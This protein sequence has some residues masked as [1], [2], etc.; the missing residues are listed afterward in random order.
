M[1][2]DI[3]VPDHA[4]KLVLRGRP[5]QLYC[6]LGPLSRRDIDWEKVGDGGNVQIV[7]DCTVKPEYSSRYKVSST[8]CQLKIESA[9]ERH[10][11][12]YVCKTADGDSAEMLIFVLGTYGLGVVGDR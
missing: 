5:V 9:D 2:T 11:G 10:G 7:D 4:R 12:Q 8:L 1:S 3:A 6:P